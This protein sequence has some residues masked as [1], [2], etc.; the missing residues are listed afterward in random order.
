[1]SKQRS[2]APSD[3]APVAWT[4]T[5]VDRVTGRKRRHTSFDR[6]YPDAYTKDVHALVYAHPDAALYSSDIAD[7]PVITD[8]D[9]R[10]I[11]DAQFNVDLGRQQKEAIRAAI[12]AVVVRHLAL[13][14]H[15]EDAAP[16]TLDDILGW[17]SAEA[18]WWTGD[19]NCRAELTSTRRFQTNLVWAS[20]TQWRD[21]GKEPR[22]GL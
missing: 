7:A 6:P 10:S 3:A 21:T 8:E 19:R 17:L 2:H 9:I 1:M 20:L 16:P 14:A 4:W 13:Y 22:H 15:P 12:A 11:W 5:T 18:E